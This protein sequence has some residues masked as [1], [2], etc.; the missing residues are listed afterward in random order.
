M[1]LSSKNNKEYTEEN[2]TEEYNK[3]SR[4]SDDWPY[5]FDPDRR[6]MYNGYELYTTSEEGDCYMGRP[7]RRN[8]EEER[9]DLRTYVGYKEKDGG[10]ENVYIDSRGMARHTAIFGQTGYGRSSLLRDILL[11][12]T[13]RGF[14]L[15]YIDPR[16]DDTRKLIR[17]VP[18]SRLD[19]IVLVKPG[20][21]DV[22]GFKI[23]LFSTLNNSGDEKY[24]YEV[25]SIA[26]NITEIIKR[27]SKDELN[28]R[29]VRLVSD[30]I[31]NLIQ[32]GEDYSLE[33][34]A[35][36]IET[37]VYDHY[38]S[39][40]PDAIESIRVEY[41]GIVD[42]R[43]MIEMAHLGRDEFES[44]LNSL[45][46][47]LMSDIVGNGSTE[48]N[49]IQIGEAIR[50][51]KIIMV[52]TSSLHS[53]ADINLVSSMVVSQVWSRIKNSNRS[54]QDNYVLCV[55]E[56]SRTLG[57]RFDI[58]GIISQARSF[59]LSVVVSSQYPSQLSAEMKQSI[60]Q[61]Q[62]IL[63][64]NVG[65]NPRDQQEAA[66]IL[67]SSESWKINDLDRFQVLGSVY[68]DGKLSDPMLFNTYG[69][70]P[71][72]RSGKDGRDFMRSE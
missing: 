33:D 37:I 38:H 34:L 58:D 2:I 19:D 55:D 21:S 60:K 27:T 25:E 29:V 39:Y 15:C 40:L 68:K 70:Y 49:E 14:G 16:G 50:Q 18:P 36:I 6:V 41:P 31:E 7:S 42:N 62:S 61:F 20:S 64:F 35:E 8:I 24:E 59:G 26:S 22:E 17:Q 57:E 67:G 48:H 10:V 45:G 23:N 4:L 54:V 56:F 66:E 1:D 44:V 51:N 5:E 53:L 63:S 12:A 28:R 13:N 43:H 65:T 47:I 69:E 72:I 32:S 3:G 30:I 46:T 9:D 52:D 11:Q 71:S